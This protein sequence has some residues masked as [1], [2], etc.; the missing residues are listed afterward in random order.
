M[1][2]QTC[3]SCGQEYE[4]WVEF[5]P[6][7]S[8]PIANYARPAGFWIRVGASIV[9]WLVFIPFAGL[10][11]WNM[12]SLRNMAVLIA[13]SAPGFF[14]KPLM[15]AFAGATVGKLA[16]GI[17]VTDGQGKKLSVF[18][19]YIRAFPFL[20]ASAVSLAGQITLFSLPEFQA[21]AS[22]ME[23]AQT[24]GITFLDIVGYITSIFVLVDCVFAAFTY[25]KRALHDM[26]AESYCV[27][28]EPQAR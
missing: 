16:C 14:Y 17:K 22:Q 18:T 10:G 20:L 21:G 7:C 5:C 1:N 12:F 28:K 6:H 9:D 23:I 25:R 8:E 2:V 15:E 13:A 11:I 19:A 27:Y 26:L 3:A 24:R 4:G